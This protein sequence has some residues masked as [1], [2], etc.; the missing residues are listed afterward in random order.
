MVDVSSVPLEIDTLVSSLLLCPI[1]PL[2]LLQWNKWTLTG[3][4][5]RYLP[6]ASAGMKKL[7]A[8][9]QNTVCKVDIRDAEFA[10]GSFML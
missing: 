5:S 7:D 3:Q 1:P 10:G 2:L 9:Q 8:K 4:A 6:V